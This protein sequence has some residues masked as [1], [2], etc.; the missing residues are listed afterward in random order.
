[1]GGTGKTPAVMAIAEE[2]L[3]RAYQPCILTRGYRGT[4]EGPCFV[5]R[6]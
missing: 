2:A 6:G 4:A 5:S 3:R 1:V